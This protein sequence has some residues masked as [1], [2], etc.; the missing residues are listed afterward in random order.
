M[1]E[2]VSRSLVGGLNAAILHRPDRQETLR[3]ARDTVDVVVHFRPSESLEYAYGPS[4]RLDLGMLT[5]NDL[6]FSCGRSARRSEFYG[7]LIAAG[8]Q[9]SGGA[10]GAPRPPAATAC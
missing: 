1:M 2:E 10:R 5:P 4:A 6:R 7:P 9:H 3:P 8:D